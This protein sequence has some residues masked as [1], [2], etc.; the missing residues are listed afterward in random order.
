[1]NSIGRV[2]GVGAQRTAGAFTP[3]GAAEMS[4]FA[5][6][7]AK[8][9]VQDEADKLMKKALKLL[10]PSILEMRFKPDWEAACPPLERAGLLYKVPH[11]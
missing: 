8:K 10:S 5:V 11:V 4:T 3:L 9:Q 2:L 1:M 7:D 6:R